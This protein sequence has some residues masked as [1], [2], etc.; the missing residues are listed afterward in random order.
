LVGGVAASLYGTAAVVAGNMLGRLAP[1]VPMALLYSV[2]CGD[3]LKAPTCAV[4]LDLQRRTTYD[5]AGA[6]AERACKKTK[7]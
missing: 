5:I 2:V 1:I 4:H 3:P 7:I 6:P